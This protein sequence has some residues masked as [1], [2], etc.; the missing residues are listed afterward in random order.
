MHLLQAEV[1]LWVVAGL[2]LPLREKIPGFF[3]CVVVPVAA[4]VLGS[5]AAVRRLKKPILI[6]VVAARVRYYECVVLGMLLE[7]SWCCCYVE[8][9]D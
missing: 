4:V 9:G 8:E 2:A 1:P 6:V 3:S 7:V 5:A